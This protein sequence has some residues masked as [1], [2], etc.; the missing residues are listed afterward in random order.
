VPGKW[1][2]LVFWSPTRPARATVPGNLPRISSPC[3]CDPPRPTVHGRVDETRAWMPA[4]RRRTAAAA[5][6]S[7]VALAAPPTLRWSRRTRRM[8]PA[9]TRSAS[10]LPLLMREQKPLQVRARSSDHRAAL[11]PAAPTHSSGHEAAP[12]PL[13]VRSERRRRSHLLFTGQHELVVAPAG[14]TPRA[15]CAK[16]CPRH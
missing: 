7:P 8:S 2:L 15:R 10:R 5:A 6:G 1:A 14:T 11:R 12:Q 3:L 16:A 4:A 13:R 9:A